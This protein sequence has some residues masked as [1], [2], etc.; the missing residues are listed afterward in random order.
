MATLSVQ[1]PTLAGAA[2][3]FTALAADG[4]EFAN[5]GRTTL[6]VRN[7]SGSSVTVTIPS[8]ANC[9]QG[10]THPLSIAVPAGADRLIGPFDVGRFG[11]TV[12]VAVSAHA[13]VSAAVVG[14]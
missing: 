12:E 8:A 7:G 5:D 4:D 3:T 14:V 13:D 9:N 2:P 6:T 11:R 1:R 10:G